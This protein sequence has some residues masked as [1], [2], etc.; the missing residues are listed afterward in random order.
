[1][2]VFDDDLAAFFTGLPVVEV[3]VGAITKGVYRDGWDEEILPG[4]ERGV[5]AERIAITFPTAWFPGLQ[6]GTAVTIGADSY[7]VV[8]RRRP[9][10]F[11]DGEITQALLKKGSA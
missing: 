6:N 7:T 1:M 10:D 11:V 8:D 4:A 3:T 5:I 2:S 9:P